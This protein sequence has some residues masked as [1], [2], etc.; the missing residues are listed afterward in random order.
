[1]HVL[2]LK[3]RA[4]VL[5]NEPLSLV[6]RGG[7]LVNCCSPTIDPSDVWQLQKTGVITAHCTAPATRSDRS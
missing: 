2:S 1:M 5:N 6:E 7:A 3:L 4:F